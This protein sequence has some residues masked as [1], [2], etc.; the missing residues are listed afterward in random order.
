MENKEGLKCYDWFFCTKPISKE[1][2]E[3]TILKKGK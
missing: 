1:D 3:K 2:V